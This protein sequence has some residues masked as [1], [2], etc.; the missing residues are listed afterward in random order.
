MK[1]AVAVAL[2]ACV[3]VVS[4]EEMKVTEEKSEKCKKQC[5]SCPV[6]E[7]SACLAGVDKDPE[8]GCCDV[9]ARFEGEKCD[10]HAHRPQHGSCGDGLT[11]KS[12][13][14]GAICQCLWE[15]IICGTDNK[16][17][18]NLCQLMSSSV[19]EG[20][21]D[22]QVKSLGPCDPGAYIISKPVSVKNHTH[23]NIV[24]SCEA[25]GF[26]APTITWKITR[27]NSKTFDCPGD[28]QNIVTSTR[29]G[30]G[31]FQV[32]GWMQIENLLKRHE[33]DYTCIAVNEQGKSEAKARIKVIEKK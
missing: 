14:G 5:E 6:L 26:P 18:T 1:L 20:T 29:G 8:C 32:T 30:P 33:G 13:R 12:V 11:C 23:T 31:K 27:A 25:I 2:V 9:C 28:D 4:G 16:T 17:Y 21:T 15:E 22:L 3:M 10:L 19:R 7:R 24:L